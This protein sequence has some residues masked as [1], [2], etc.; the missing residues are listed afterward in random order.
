MTSAPTHARAHTHTHT[1][2][3]SYRCRDFAGNNLLA[4][5]LSA[6]AINSCMSKLSIPDF[7]ETNILSLCLNSSNTERREV[8]FCTLWFIDV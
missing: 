8:V 4:M 6:S 1:H 5:I 7:N 2:T 3:P